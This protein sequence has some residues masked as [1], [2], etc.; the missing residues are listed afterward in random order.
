[1]TDAQRSFEDAMQMRRHILG[2]EYVDRAASD[3][4]EAG[5]DFQRYIISSSWSVWTRPGLGT[6]E[7]SLL[8]LAMTAALGRMEEFALHVRSVE[9]AGV[10]DD[11]L[12]EVVLQIAAYCGGP[13][14]IA[15]RRALVAE[16][17]NESMLGR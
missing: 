8:V 15:A 9:R 11:E 10:K 12:D 16:R 14:G 4:S 7:R 2:D 5:M 17:N 6:R 3:Q 13:A 1:M